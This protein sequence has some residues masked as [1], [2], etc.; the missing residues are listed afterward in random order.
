MITFEKITAAAKP[1]TVP[2]KTPRLALMTPSSIANLVSVG[3]TVRINEPTRSNARNPATKRFW[4]R[5]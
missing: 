5:K 4:W 3:G 2:N 1:P